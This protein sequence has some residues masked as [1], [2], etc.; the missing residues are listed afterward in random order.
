MTLIPFFSVGSIHF[1]ISQH[2]LEIAMGKPIRRGRNRRDEEELHYHN[3]IYRFDA[4]GLVEMTLDVE[5]ISVAGQMIRFK[6]LAGF[7]KTGDEQV[8]E[9]VGFLVSPSYGIAVDPHFES[10]VTFMPR[11]RLTTW[12]GVAA[13]RETR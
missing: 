8:E 3:G 13:R 11:R 2:A 12:L 9:A 4:L 5:S 6:E 1:D 7:L 10:W